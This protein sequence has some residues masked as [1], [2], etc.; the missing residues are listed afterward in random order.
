MHPFMRSS[1]IIFFVAIVSSVVLL[2]LLLSFSSA[3]QSTASAA[4]L[5]HVDFS[6]LSLISLQEVDAATNSATTSLATTTAPLEKPVSHVAKQAAT[7]PTS[8]A[9]ASN[10]GPGDPTRLI[11]PS[12]GLDDP[13]DGVGID[14]NGDM[15]VPSGKTRD[16]GWYR[17]GTVPGAVGSAV[18]DAHVFAAFSALKDVKAGDDIY[19]QTAAGDTLHFKVETTDTYPLAD[20]PTQT[21][22]NRSDTA[23]LN[24]ITCAGN[25]IDND[26]TYDHRLIVYAVLVS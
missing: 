24:L 12:I 3:T 21:L 20:V 25:L 23:R 8:V 4:Q 2:P 1:R 9:I 16:V 10:E 15:A 11:V 26:T 5:P 6:A 22:F 18:L 14:E 17:D 13:V 19:V 7:P